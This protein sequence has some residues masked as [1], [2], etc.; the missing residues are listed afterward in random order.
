MSIGRDI[1]M[2]L[3]IKLAR[4]G[5]VIGVAMIMTSCGTSY[6]PNAEGNEKEPLPT[7]PTKI[8]LST[9]EP[10]IGLPI[11][12]VAPELTNEVWLN[13]EAPIRLADLKGKVVLLDFWTFG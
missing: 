5:A 9:S 12:G 3:Y 8:V 7:S 11:L 2:S 13:T 6:S 4:S 1:F 10:D